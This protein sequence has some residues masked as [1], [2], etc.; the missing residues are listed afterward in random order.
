MIKCPRTL[1]SEDEVSEKNK[2]NK[3]T[4]VHVRTRAH[5]VKSKSLNIVKSVHMI[6]FALRYFT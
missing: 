5:G 3:N 2:D 6:T 4:L 1:E